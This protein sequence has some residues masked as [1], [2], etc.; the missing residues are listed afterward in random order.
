MWNADKKLYD[1]SKEDTTYKGKAA[2]IYFAVRDGLYK[3]IKQNTSINKIDTTAL[4][5]LCR[6]E[7][8]VSTQIRA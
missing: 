8:D 6:M 2:K 3:A 4:M 1:I 7:R 5:A